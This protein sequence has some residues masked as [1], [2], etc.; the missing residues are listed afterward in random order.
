MEPVTDGFFVRGT[1]A[2]SGVLKDSFTPDKLR[3]IWG[4]LPGEIAAEAV[5]GQAGQPAVLSSVEL[6]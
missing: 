1:A 2:N 3:S 5:A 6:L 4:S